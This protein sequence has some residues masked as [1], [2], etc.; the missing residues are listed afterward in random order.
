MTQ[1]KEKKT[2]MSKFHTKRPVALLCIVLM[3]ML[4]LGCGR[5]FSWQGDT[6]TD[7]N[8]SYR[9]LDKGWSY[10]GTFKIR[11]GVKKGGNALYASDETEWMIKEQ[12]SLLQ[13]MDYRP[14]I[15]SDIVLLDPADEHN[16]IQI[17]NRFLSE[18]AATQLRSYN[19]ENHG[20]LIKKIMGVTPTFVEV[21]H[22][23]IDALYSSFDGGCFVLQE[24]TLYLGLYKGS[25]DGF[26]AYETIPE[27]SAL[28]RE[29]LE[30]IK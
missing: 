1:I 10:S 8:A 17:N 9:Y 15:R 12:K 25:Y 29:V 22:P 27:G 20:K 13:D 28:Y 3:T 11:I 2:K 7:G 19:I 4:L 16:R 6:L 26:Y 30:V 23:E 18:A 5:E 14:L 21:I 24:K